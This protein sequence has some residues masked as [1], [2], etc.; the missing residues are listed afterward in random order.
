MVKRV[1]NWY[2]VELNNVFYNV[3]IQKDPRTIICEPSSI[4]VFDEGFNKVEDYSIWD[5]IERIM[6]EMDWKYDMVG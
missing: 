6:D 3:V 5:D 4:L 2:E 1:G